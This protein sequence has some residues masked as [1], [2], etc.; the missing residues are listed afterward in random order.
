MVNRVILMVMD[1]LGVGAL[2]DAQDFGDRGSNT[3]GHI[4]DHMPQMTIPHL[5]ELGLTNIKGVDREPWKIDD[6][7]GAFGR[8][9]EVSNGKD[10]ITGHWEITGIETAMPFKT[11]PDGFPKA[12][13]REFERQIGREVLGNYP[14]SGTEIIETLGHEHETTG[15]PIVYTSA[16]SVFQIAAN[17][18]IIEI[19]ELY[20]I[21]EVA[22][23]LLVG[24]FACGRVIARPYEMVE[25]KRVRTAQR[26][27]YSVSPPQKTLLDHIRDSGK[28]VHCIGKIGDIFNGQGVSVS[29][30][31][32]NN[33]DGVAKTLEA[34][35]EDFSGLIFTNL[36]DFDALFG[37]RRDVIGYGR[38]LESF[39]RGL[40]S[41]IKAMKPEDVLILCADHG[42]DPTHG[43]WDHT[44]EHIPILV[45]GKSVKANCDL[46]TRDTFADIGQTIAHIL[47]VKS[48]SMGQSFWEAIEQK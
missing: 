48:L 20:R 26:R 18:D 24:E 7:R 40:G 21:C 33:E 42:N 10:T 34:I 45:Y 47:Q 32:E 44:R 28:K 5:R 8:A 2:E 14:A 1:S 13:I 46:G 3:L 36:V 43:G 19:E 41:M 22:R 12:F 23:K 30:H 25:G 16:D 9:K 35:E 29:V 38:A 11:Y 37:H 17:V 6:P 39:D 15:K 27:D 31:T 4:M